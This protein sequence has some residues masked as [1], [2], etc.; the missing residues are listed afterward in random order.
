MR[1]GRF[2]SL[3]GGGFFGRMYVCVCVCVCVCVRVCVKLVDQSMCDTRSMERAL[4]YVATP[5]PF[6]SMNEKTDWEYLWKYGGQI[7]TSPA[8]SF[9][10]SERETDIKCEKNYPWKHRCWVCIT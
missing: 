8:A 9:I 1:K 2:R 5:S 10:R 4:V 3:R 7:T 6:S